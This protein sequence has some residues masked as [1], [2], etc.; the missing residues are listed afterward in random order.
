MKTVEENIVKVDE[1]L[2]QLYKGNLEAAIEI[3]NAQAQL[4]LGEMQMKTA[5]AQLEAGSSA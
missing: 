3:S 2:N 1:G 4:N 5:E